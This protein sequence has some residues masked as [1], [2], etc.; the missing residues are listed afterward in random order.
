MQK[1]CAR[2]L[3]FEAKLLAILTSHL[4][5]YS[6]KSNAMK[7]HNEE[8]LYLPAERR[9]R[10]KQLGTTY[11]RLLETTLREGIEQQAVRADTDTHFAAYSIIGLCN[12]WGAVLYR[13]ESVGV[14]ETI[15]QCMDLILNGTLRRPA[16]DRDN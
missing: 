9:V 10:L 11:R 4:T 14:Y 8:R 16:I 7:V 2:D 12:Y 1:I 15:E 13:D 3:P 5:N 6:Q